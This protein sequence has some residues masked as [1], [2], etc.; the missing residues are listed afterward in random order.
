[1][2]LRS[3]GKEIGRKTAVAMMIAGVLVVLAWRYQLKLFGS[4]YEILPGLVTA[5]SIY[6]ISMLFRKREGQGET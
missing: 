6:F 5:F 4:V 3:F 1:M 2:I